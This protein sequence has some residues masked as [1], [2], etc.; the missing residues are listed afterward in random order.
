VSRPTKLL[1]RLYGAIILARIFAP[2]VF[3]LALPIMILIGLDST[4]DAIGEP[5]SRLKDNVVTVSRDM[6]SVKKE[7]DK[8]VKGIQKTTS[9]A[10][11]AASSATNFVGG[12]LGGDAGRKVS[13]ASATIDAGAARAAEDLKAK[14][15][16]AFP[17]VKDALKV[18]EG[19]K[20]SA[21]QWLLPVA[22]VLF[23]VLIFFVST[24]IELLICSIGRI[25]EAWSMLVGE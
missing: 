9:G 23:I 4:T 11:S 20:D 25:R 14:F 10:A 16:G 3:L 8:V 7:L 17:G 5:F 24:Y 2:A 21:A 15:N 18:V 6:D 19:L 22:V 13:A 12:L 1:R